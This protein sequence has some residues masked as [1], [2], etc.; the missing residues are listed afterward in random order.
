M[1]D[2]DTH[3]QPCRL[4]ARYSDVSVLSVDYRLAPEHP[5]PAA[6]DDVLAV[7]D[8]AVT[9]ADELRIDPARLGIA[10]SSAGG[11]LAASVAQRSARGEAPPLVFQLLD[12]RPSPSKEEFVDTPGFDG[13]AV[14]Q[15]WRYYLDGDL[16]SVDAVP[17]ACEQLS[18]LPAALITCSELD[19]LRDE[20][21]DCALRLMWSGVATELHV[22]PGSCH[23]F[24]SMAPDSAM[25]RQL[26]ALQSAALR[27][28]L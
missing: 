28:A 21:I 4:L 19:P 5:C 25:S 26:F 11:A 23:G 7:L 18:G 22:F 13:P 16:G 2:L 20:A 27:R 9:E 12:N 14:A 8:W 10:G 15:M 17:G 24:D 3:D 1:G 6:L